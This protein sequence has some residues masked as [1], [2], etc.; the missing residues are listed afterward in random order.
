MYG[1]LTD[2]FVQCLRGWPEAAAF[3]LS[4]I[5]TNDTDGKAIVNTMLPCTAVLLWNNRST[6]TFIGG[7]VW[8]IM[9]LRIMTMID[10]INYSVTEDDGFQSRMESMASRQ[11]RYFLSQATNPANPIFRQ[12]RLDYGFSIKLRDSQTRTSV[13]FETNVGGEG[14]QIKVYDSYFEVNILWPES[15]GLPTENI[16]LE[17]IDLQLYDKDLTT[18]DDTGHIQQTVIK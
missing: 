12:L 13:A 3:N 6:H 8:E 1:E 16:P 18:G 9:Q 14:K 7:R 2:A 5:K 17:E 15:M 4:V 10:L 11:K